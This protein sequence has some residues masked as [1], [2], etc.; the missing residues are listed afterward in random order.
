MIYGRGASLRV[1]GFVG[2]SHFGLVAEINLFFLYS[3]SNLSFLLSRDT[4][5]SMS[6]RMFLGVEGIIT[7]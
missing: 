2:D 5:I 6:W 1:T 7:D 3:F 4:F